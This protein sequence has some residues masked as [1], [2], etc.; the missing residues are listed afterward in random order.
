MFFI[1][2]IMLECLKI[3]RLTCG[4]SNLTLVRVSH[5]SRMQLW[6]ISILMSRSRSRLFKVGA[7]SYTLD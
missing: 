3:P 2:I 6:L 5:S 4:G 1:V 7:G